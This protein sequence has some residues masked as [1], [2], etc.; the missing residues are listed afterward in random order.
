MSDVMDLHEIRGTGPH[1]SP[2]TRLIA[3]E[4]YDGP[5]TGLMQSGAGTWYWFE[6]VAWDDQC[7]RRAFLVREIGNAAAE[8]LAA[9]LAQIDSPRTPEWWLKAGPLG[10]AALDVA[11]LELNAQ[12]AAP[13][14]VAISSDLLRSIEVLRPV[15]TETGAVNKLNE[16]APGAE[17]SRTPFEVW[18]AF[19]EADSR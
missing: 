17:I 12:E 7:L 10:R 19:A 1:V 9:V 5:T 14:F 4:V 18:S 8:K 13:S 3:M 2:V 11:L 6:M 15:G 16:R